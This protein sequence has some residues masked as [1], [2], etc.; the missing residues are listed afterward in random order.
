MSDLVLEGVPQAFC[1]ALAF[2]GKEPQGTVVLHEAF[3]AGGYV[4]HQSTDANI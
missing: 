4:V 2:D 1:F 3:Q